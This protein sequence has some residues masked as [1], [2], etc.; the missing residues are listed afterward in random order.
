MT[1]ARGVTIA[2]VARRIPHLS[3]PNLIGLRLWNVSG[4]P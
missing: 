1:P 3:E 4:N 2:R